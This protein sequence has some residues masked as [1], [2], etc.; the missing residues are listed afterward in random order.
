[1]PDWMTI[2]EAADYLRCSVSTILRRIK[3]D[4][5]K[6]YKSGNITRVKRED[7]DA[8]LEGGEE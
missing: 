1:V 6:A 7:L 5:L 3:A 2:N 4:Q 8:M